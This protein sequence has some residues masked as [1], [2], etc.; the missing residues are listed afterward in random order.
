MQFQWSGIGTLSLHSL[1]LSADAEGKP[2]RDNG[3]QEGK[4]V[5][6]PLE[7]R[8]YHGLGVGREDERAQNQVRV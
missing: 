8:R 6:S 7:L 3:G 4:T 5:V 1:S 2:E